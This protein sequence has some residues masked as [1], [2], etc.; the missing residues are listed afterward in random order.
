MI[1]QA[2][3]T[4]C[5]HVGGEVFDCDDLGAL[6]ERIEE[7]LPMMQHA[8]FRV[9]SEAA[10]WGVMTRQEIPELQDQLMGA[11]EVAEH[12]KW[13]PKKVANYLAGG[14]AGIPEPITHLKC[15]PIWL[16]E[17]V[18]AWAQQRGYAPKE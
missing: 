9:E 17:D 12:V 16:R 2:T 15:G 11:A 4:G 3:R 7:S 8:V 6:C 1:A 18:V 13:P 10:T 14:K 5:T